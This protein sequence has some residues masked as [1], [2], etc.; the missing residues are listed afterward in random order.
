MQKKFEVMSLYV[1]EEVVQYQD[2]IYVD[3]KQRFFISREVVHTLHNIRIGYT[4][5][6]QTVSSCDIVYF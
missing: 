1:S 5:M 4:L 2:W 3:D 6:L